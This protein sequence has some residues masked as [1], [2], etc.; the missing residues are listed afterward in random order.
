MISAHRLRNFAQNHDQNISMKIK[1]TLTQHAIDRIIERSTASPDSI[2]DMIDIGLSI[3][4]GCGQGSS[5]SH[6]LLYVP[7][8]STWFIVIRDL[9]NFE[10]ITF[11]P[12]DYHETLAWKISFDALECAKRLTCGEKQGNVKGED[13]LKEPT[14]YKISVVFYPEPQKHVRRNIGSWRISPY[15]PV[16]DL[17]NDDEFIRAILDRMKE[18]GIALHEFYCLGLKKSKKDTYIYLPTDILMQRFHEV[19]Q[20]VD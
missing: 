4:I 18:K 19:V 13:H 3:P 8:D 2:L 16:F 7:D 10:I 14:T 5:R 15:E 9:K 6:E 12:V 20:S 17:M 1:H 11:L